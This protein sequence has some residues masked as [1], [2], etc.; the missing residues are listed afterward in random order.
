[1]LDTV[2]I[3]SLP[4]KD[5]QSDLLEHQLSMKLS[6]CYRASNGRLSCLSCHDPHQQPTGAEAPG[7]FRQRC[8][9]CHAA[10]DC[11]QSLQIRLEQ[12]PHDNCIGCH[13]PKRNIQQ[14]SHSALTNHRIPVRADEAL[15]P[16]PPELSSPELPGLLLLDATRGSP[17][18][19][20][21]TRLSIYGELLNR[22]PQ[23]QK[24][25]FAILENLSHSM[26]DDPLVLAALGRKAL[27]EKNDHA[28]DYLARAVRGGT[29]AKATFMDLVE[30]LTQAGRGAEAITVLEQ[31]NTLYPYSAE[32]RKRL[33]LCYIQSKRYDRAGP[34]LEQY[35]QDFPEDSFMRDQLN[36]VHKR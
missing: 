8:L 13:M 23:F 20:E 22:D 12:Q 31:A 2:A 32:I 17:V 15:P 25:Y 9:T 18:L 1:L 4:P 5:S 11:K 6:K 26:P 36:R 29:P 30:A 19:P 27:L 34:T 7:Y 28:L 21:I 35:V 10:K 24:P 16:V 14:I 33:L 3:V